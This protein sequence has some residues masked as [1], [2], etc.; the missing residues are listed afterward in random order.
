MTGIIVTG[1]GHFPTGILSAIA[2][3]AGKPENTAGVDFE[4]GCSSSDL[5]EAMKLAVESLDG[6]EVLILADLVGGTPFNVAAVLK[7]EYT[8]KRIKVMAGVNMASMVEAVFSRPMYGLDGLV[9]AVLTAGREG[10]KD[11]DGLGNDEEGPEFEGG[12]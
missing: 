8:G 3:V 11:L 9:E 6:E 7:Q 2:L 1:H 5:E 4:E 10:I 12:L